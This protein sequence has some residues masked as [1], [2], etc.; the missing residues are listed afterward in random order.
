ML[1]S[2]KEIRVFNPDTNVFVSQHTLDCEISGFVTLEPGT[3]MCIVDSG[4]GIMFLDEEFQI[5]G[6]ASSKENMK[7]F[8]I[9]YLSPRRYVQF[10]KS[11]LSETHLSFFD[12]SS[13]S[14][15][16]FSVMRYANEDDLDEEEC[17]F[18]TEREICVHLSSSC[19][20]MGVHCDK[21]HVTV[22][23]D[24]WEMFKI[25]LEDKTIAKNSVDYPSCGE[26]GFYV[27]G[28]D[29][30]WMVDKRNNIHLYDMHQHHKVV[31]SASGSVCDITIHG[32]RLLVMTRHY[33]TSGYSMKLS[34]YESGTVDV[35][36]KKSDISDVNRFRYGSGYK[37]Y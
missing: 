32:G 16:Y 35:N 2:G 30:L 12:R 17:P 3:Y 25:H 36:E 23:G 15:A 34:T 13:S 24:S 19:M 28:A 31:L 21:T 20:K 4:K 18:I 7:I 8:A 37:S 1:Y 33:S 14:E 9:D 10:E 27:D 29:S 11:K 26:Y 22:C 6:C 5:V